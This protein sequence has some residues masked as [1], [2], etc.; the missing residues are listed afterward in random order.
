MGNKEFLLNKFVYFEPEP[1]EFFNDPLLYNIKQ[2]INNSKITYDD[3][4]KFYIIN[5]N[6]SNDN[7]YSKASNMI[8][9]LR[10]NIDIKA[11]SIEDWCNICNYD[12]IFKLVK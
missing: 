5:Y 12:F 1:D 8:K 10:K 9:S 2:M 4:R 11:S 6:M 7:A 3:I